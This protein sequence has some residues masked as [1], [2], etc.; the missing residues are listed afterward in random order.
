MDTLGGGVVGG[1]LKPNA[2]FF[3]L[4]MFSDLL[5]FTQGAHSQTNLCVIG[6]CA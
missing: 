3:S 2:M 4:Q 1:G 6:L 5:N